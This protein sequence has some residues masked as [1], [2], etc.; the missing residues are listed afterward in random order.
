MQQ[1]RRVTLKPTSSA[2]GYLWCA[3]PFGVYIRAYDFP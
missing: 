3:K 2:M 1:I